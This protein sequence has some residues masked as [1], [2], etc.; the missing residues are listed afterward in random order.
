MK[1]TADNVGLPN[2][3]GRINSYNAL[4]HPLV[5]GGAAAPPPCIIDADCDDGNVCNGVETCD[6]NGVCVAGTPLNCDDGVYC[7]GI[8]TCDPGSGCQAG[9]PPDC[10]DGVPCTVDS[11]DEATDS[12]DHTPN[13]GSCATGETCHVTSG[14]VG[15]VPLPCLYHA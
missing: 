10:D 12:C 8:E 5:T 2:G 14:C 15:E 6:P 13:N 1:E 4:N 11:C 9:T 7:N 3:K